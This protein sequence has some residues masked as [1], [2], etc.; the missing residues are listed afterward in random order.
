M[1]RID[2]EIR[3]ACDAAMKLIASIQAP[4]VIRKILAHPEQAALVREVV[5]LLGPRTPHNG[6]L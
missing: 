3:Q 6:G 2:V 4:A 5:R 1:F